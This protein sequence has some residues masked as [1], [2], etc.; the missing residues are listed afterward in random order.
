L[1][2]TANYLLA[3]CSF[4]ELLHQHGHLL[5]LYMAISGQNFLPY[6]LAV[7]IC[8]VSLFGL[9]GIPTSMAFT[10]LDRLLAIVFPK[11]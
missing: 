9:G 5:F 6:G 3:L 1:K 10:G 2:E 4:F 8:A 11:L 7:R